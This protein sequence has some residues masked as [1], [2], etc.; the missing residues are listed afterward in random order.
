[1]SS[2]LYAGWWRAD[3]LPLRHMIAERRSEKLRRHLIQCI[4]LLYGLLVL[5]AIIVASLLYTVVAVGPMLPDVEKTRGE[6][7]PCR[8]CRARVPFRITRFQFKV[9][10][11]QS[12]KQCACAMQCRYTLK[13]KARPFIEATPSSTEPRAV[14]GSKYVMAT[15]AQ[16][17]KLSER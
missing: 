12:S 4:V 15:L 10:E 2:M 13:C 5:S 6:K 3:R 17:V 8:S 9:S 16:F 7:L 1:M 11:V 14:L